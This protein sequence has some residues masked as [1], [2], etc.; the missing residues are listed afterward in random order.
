VKTNVGDLLLIYN[1][2][3]PL[4][5]ARVEDI[6]ADIKPGWW[7]ITLML[8]QVPIQYITWILR[9]EYIDGEFFAI[10][11]KKMRLERV[12]EVGISLAM[13]TPMEPVFRSNMEDMPAEDQKLPDNVIVLRARKNKSTPNDN[14]PA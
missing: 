1:E 6:N 11:G 3:T 2:H 7:H 12:P 14:N 9:D 4:G 5:F 10:E 8:L 13:R